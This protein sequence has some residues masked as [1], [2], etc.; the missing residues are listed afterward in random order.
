MNCNKKISFMMMIITLAGILFCLFNGCK[1]LAENG[2]EISLDETASSFK[3]TEVVDDST[4]TNLLD[5]SSSKE[6]TYGDNIIVTIDWA[7]DDRTSIT[8]NDVFTYQLPDKITFNTVTDKD[9]VDGNKVVG[10][11]SIIDNKIYIQ[12]SDN[13]FCDQNQRQGSLSFS[14][15]IDDDGKGNKPEEEVTIEFPGAVNLTVH[16]VP[17]TENAKVSVSKKIK[18]TDTSIRDH[19]YDCYIAI[20]SKGKNNNISFY[21]EMYPGMSLYSKP[22]YYTDENYSEPLDEGRLTDSTKAPGTSVREINSVI[23]TMN[24][25]DVIYVHYQVKVDPAM[26]EW[27][28]AKEYVSNGGFGNFYPNSYIGKVPNRAVVKSDEDPEEHTSWADVITLRGSFDKWAN[29]NVKNDG[30]LNWQIILYSIYGSDY[31]KG[32]IR[33]VLPA[34]TSIVPSSLHAKTSN[35]EISG[36]ITVEEEPDSATGDTVVRLVFSKDVMDYLKSD[37][38]ADVLIEYQTK[39]D[40]QEEDT[41]RYYNVAEIYYDGVS[42]MTA[43]NDMNY[44]KPEALTKNGKYNNATA[45]DAEYEIVINPAALD[46]DPN[47][48]VLYLEDVMSSS[49]ELVAGS[50]NVSPAADDFAF[51]ASSNK[52]TFT[53]KDSTSYKITYSARM[54]LPLGTDLDSS[55]SGNDAKLYSKNKV[56][57]ETSKSFSG[58]VLKAAGSSVSTKNPGTIYLT[59]HDADSSNKL[60]PDAKFE[61]VAMEGKDEVT[62]TSNVLKATT[63]DKGSL[64]FGELERGV[65]FMLQETDAPDGYELEK[66]PKFYAFATARSEFSNKVTFAGQEYPL[67]IIDVGGVDISVVVVNK[68]KE[69]A[70]T[71]ETTTEEKTTEKKTEEKTSEV[72]TEAT[73]EATSENTTA[74]TEATT[75]TTSEVTTEATT[76]AVTELTTEEVTT[77]K[78]TELPTSEATTEEK[79]TEE[80]TTEVTTTEEK[81]TEV[82]TEEKTTEEKTTEVT[83]EE[84]T[85]EVTT[86]EKATEEKTTEVTT[87]EEKTTEAL[88][89]EKTTEEKTTE[90]KTTEVTTAE[91]KTT[92]ATTEE[93]TTEEKTT[94]E[95]TTEVTT[96]EEKTT[97]ATTEEKTTEEKK[98]VVSSEDKTTEEKTTE[99]TTAVITSNSD[100]VNKTP[101]S[102]PKTEA[103]TQITTEKGTYSGEDTKSG[104]K[105]SE[106]NKSKDSKDK[107]S[108]DSKNK[109][110]DDKTDSTTKDTSDKTTQT[111][112]SS[113]AGSGVTTESS[114]QSS[115]SVPS[116]GRTSSGVRTGD[117]AAIVLAIMLAVISIVGTVAI[118]IVKKHR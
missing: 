23:D 75:E 87:T 62:K 25:E 101:S 109:T 31:S 103:S 12:Y 49:Y 30:L 56:L 8:T 1:V 89:E 32:Y 96:T 34:H 9:I 55:N 50:I 33:D 82:T 105:T 4:G 115:P 91:E 26:Y 118:I 11:F 27:E 24:N 93:K 47:S 51:D 94:E 80:K 114:T 29:G 44:T 111:S 54:T 10:K 46:L 67:N 35:G 86:E 83:T 43:S 57:K 72:T 113:S 53:L 61:L 3:I 2:K 112:T 13:T 97:E 78:A 58:K 79:T 19:I 63:D 45:P 6:V 69:E 5:D 104:E 40:E 18:D 81:T 52:M 64:T 100:K 28:S 88:T 73:T 15:C 95:K 66:T 110:S 7:F 85:T 108:D 102:D 16:M 92:E 71:E 77:E 74:S 90:E 17:P 70:T 106:D 14:G 60:L 42:L 117:N 98:E 65:V 36:G 39:V 84:K 68:V 107:K 37:E 116:N 76:E 22:E 20:K 59:K 48:D 99:T 21:D 38:N 41:K